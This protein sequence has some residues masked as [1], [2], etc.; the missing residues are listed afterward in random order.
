MQRLPFTS[1]PCAPRH[2]Q[3]F[4][5]CENSLGSVSWGSSEGAESYLA[6][7]VGQDNHTHVC[8]TNTTICSWDDL[9]CG[10]RY[11]VHVIANDNLCSSMPSNSTSIQ[12]GKHAFVCRTG[13]RDVKKEKGLRGKCIV[14]T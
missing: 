12:M 6:I 9:H 14:Q 5:Q 8:T 13:E 11:T 2:V 4:V 3:S 10:E 7:A 1:G